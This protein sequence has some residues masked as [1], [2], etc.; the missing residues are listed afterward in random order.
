VRFVRSA[1]YMRELPPEVRAAV[2][3]TP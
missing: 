3:P 2:Y 1:P